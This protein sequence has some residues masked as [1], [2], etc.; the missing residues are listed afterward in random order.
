MTT[1]I[2]KIDAVFEGGGVKGIGLA[3]AVAVTEAQGYQFENIA[4]TSAGAIV[5]ALVAAGYSA[6]ELKELIEGLDY[7]KFQ[8]KDAIDSIP[9]VGATL[10]V[11]LEKGL[12]EGKYFEGWMQEQLAQK[13]IH[14]FGD[15]VIEEYKDD[16]R[17]RYRLQVIATD[18]TN[19]QLLVLPRDISRYGM[20][21]D[22][23]GVAHAVRMSMSIP[24]FF[25]PVIV[26]DAQGQSNFIVDGGVLS[27][28]PVWLFDD[29]SSNPP[30]PTLG[31]KLVDPEEGKPR[32]ITG[33]ISFLKA[34]FFT[35]MEAHDALYIEESNFARTIP[36]P[37]M[38][39]G[40][41]EF[42]VTPEKRDRLY[43]SGVAAAEEFFQNWDFAQ[44]NS[45]FPR[46]EAVGRQER[47]WTAK[48]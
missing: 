35:M 11:L 29:G 17:Y 28:Y 40:T 42:D 1:E 46:G 30:W 18:I 13:G 12:Y 16:P 36:I 6:S 24:L 15:L 7:L 34:M 33:I 41:T 20:Q 45:K 48:V 22:S 3:G 5:A 32:E 23:L 44:F 38:G 43:A 47:L 25:E 8:D 4:G 31:Y 9:H 10:S 19:G 21:P 37:T 14:T 2:K 39:V 26:K 27:N